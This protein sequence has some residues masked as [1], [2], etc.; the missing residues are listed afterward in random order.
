M[1]TGDCTLIY[2]VVSAYVKSRFLP[3]CFNRFSV[4]SFL[5]EP[6]SSVTGIHALFTLLLW[7]VLRLFVQRA[8]KDIEVGDCT[9][10][11]S[12][13]SRRLYYNFNHSLTDNFDTIL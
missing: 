13:A 10:H 9:S 3:T 4:H 2:K 7:L 8:A 11:Q 1:V 5:A 12:K 6:V